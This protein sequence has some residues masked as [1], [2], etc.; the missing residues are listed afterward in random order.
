MILKRYGTML[1]SV[2]PHFDAR[3]M[4]EIGFQR[5]H[6]LSLAAAEFTAAYN[7]IELHELVAQADGLVQ[8]DAEQAVLRHLHDQLSH[9]ESKHPGRVLVLESEPGRDY[10]KLH[11]KIT[12]IV[13]EGENKLHFHRTVDPPLRMGVYAPRQ[14]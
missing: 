12:N 8:M 11:E 7:L 6:E 4:N 1:H 10:P 3:A 2:E 13:V 9:L 14:S 5:S